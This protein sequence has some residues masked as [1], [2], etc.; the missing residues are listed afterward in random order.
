MEILPGNARLRMVLG[1]LTIGAAGYG[2]G[3]AAARIANAL[4]F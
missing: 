3:A 4:G 1:I 2:L